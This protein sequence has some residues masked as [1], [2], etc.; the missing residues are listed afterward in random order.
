MGE[1][2]WLLMWTCTI[3]PIPLYFKQIMSESK[4]STPILNAEKLYNSLLAQLRAHEAVESFELASPA[5]RGAWVSERL[6]DELG[7]PDHGVLNVSF[8]RDDYQDKGVGALNSAQGMATR[9]PFEVEGASVSLPA[10]QILVLERDGVNPFHF[11]L[12]PHA[13][14]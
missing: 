7:L 9:I 6:A 11:V 4:T 14:A 13:H 2:L 8:H 5:S 12:E 10:D 3:D 1:A